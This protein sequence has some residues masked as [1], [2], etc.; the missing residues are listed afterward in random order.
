MR[1]AVQEAADTF[2]QNGLRVTEATG[3]WSVCSSNPPRLK[4]TGGGRAPI[5]GTSSEAAIADVSKALA[6]SGWT[7]TTSSSAP[8]PSATLEND[9]LNLSLGESRRYPGTI[10]V[11]VAGPCIDTTDE[12]DS[13]LGETE[14]VIG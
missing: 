2:D 4:Y 11:S 14:R 8:R 1:A 13:L 12:Q 10:T 5:K 9:R 6:E 7:E 3:S